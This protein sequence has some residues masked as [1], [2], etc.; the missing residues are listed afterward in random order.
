M[1]RA[2]LIAVVVAALLPVAPARAD[3]EVA[4]EPFVPSCVNRPGDPG[5]FEGPVAIGLLAGDLGAGRRACPRSELTLG[6]RALATIDTP[7]FYGNLAVGARL[8][9]SWS[10]RGRGE[11]FASFTFV[12]WQFVQNATL[13][14]S[15]LTA[16]PL[17][18][19]GS[20]LAYD[21]RGLAIS[22]YA[23]V[24]LPTDGRTIGLE[25]GVSLA[26]IFARRFG[27]HLLAAG[28]LSAG[29][30]PGPTSARGGALILV[31]LAWTPARWFSFTFDAQLHFG[32][33][34]PLDWF[35]PVAALRFR[36]WRGLGAELSALVPVVGGDRH[37]TALLLRIGWRF[38][39]TR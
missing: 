9:G 11:L 15:N 27:A 39:R 7:G 19:G 6:A 36:L 26:G 3:V 23:R 38:D 17:T 16:G 37:D 35:A 1:S 31:G 2:V 24:L 28:D 14:A 33:L 30:G 21:T 12:D 29:I 13:K 8:E 20:V 18:V 32:A 22:P 5:L 4:K 34:A 25:Y 10:I